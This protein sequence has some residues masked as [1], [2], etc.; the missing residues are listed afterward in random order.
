MQPNSTT[1]KHWFNGFKYYVIWFVIVCELFPFPELY[2]FGHSARK[3]IVYWYIRFVQL[4]AGAVF[5]VVTATVF[6]EL[7]NGLNE[8]RRTWVTWVL[9]VVTWAAAVQALSMLTGL[10][11][12][13]L[14]IRF[15]TD[16]PD[17]S[18]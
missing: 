15:L 17:L 16:W 14:G 10:G 18:G 13:H 12:W 7:Q 1:S 3:D 6:T 11:L 2:L 9:A 4:I 5:G 8:S